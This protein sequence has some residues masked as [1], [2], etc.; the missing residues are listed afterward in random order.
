MANSHGGVVIDQQHR[1]RLTDNIAASDNHSFLPSNRNIAALENLNDSRRSTRN[2]PRSLGGKQ[3]NIDRMKPIHILT[4]IHRHQYSFR[5][6]LRRQRKLHQNPI[7]LVPLIQIRHQ[8]QQ[9]FS[10]H[11]IR[12]R[13][14]LAVNSQVFA[15]LHL[16]ADINF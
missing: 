4:R 8:L 1:H 14:L 15:T 2:Q 5:I 3:S 7:N 12:G 6:N 13:V 16:A 10:R 9:E 11:R